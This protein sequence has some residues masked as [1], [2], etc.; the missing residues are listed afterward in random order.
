LI[1]SFFYI[2]LSHVPLKNAFLMPTYHVIPHTHWDREWYLSFDHFRVLLTHLMDDLLEIL[3]TNPDYK[4][5]TLDGQTSVL[6]DYL[7]IRPDRRPLIEKYVREGRLFIGPWYILP[8]EHLVSGEA[9]I[10]NLIRGRETAHAF[11]GSMDVGYIPDSFGHIAQMPQILQGFGIDSA[12]VWRGFGGEPGQEPSEYQWISPDGSQVLMEHLSDVGYSAAYFNSTDM[13]SAEERFEDFASRV[14]FRAQSDER[15]MLCGGDHHWPYRNL[16]LVLAHLNEQY[17]GDKVLVHS[18]ITAFMEAMK[19]GVAGKKLPQVH[20]EMRFGYRWAFNVTGGV[21]STR[22]YLKQANTAGQLLLERIL[23]PLDAITLWHGGRSQAHLIRQGWTYLM[24]NHPHDSICGCSIDPVHREMETRFEKLQEL[25]LGVERFAMMQILPD[26]EGDRGDDESLSLFNPSPFTRDE[27]VETDVEF[28]NQQIV[29]GLN[30]DVVVDPALPPVAGFRLQDSNGTNIPFEILDRKVDF[31]ISYN[32]FDYPAQSLVERFRLRFRSG[33]VPA[34]GMKA[35]RIVRTDTFAAEP[36]TLPSPSGHRISNGLV[37]LEAQQDGSYMLTDHETGQT[38]GPMGYFED[39]GDAGDEYNWSPPMKGDRIYDSRSSAKVHIE[40]VDGGLR[41]GL[42]ITGSWELP[43]GVT[44]DDNH[45][46]DQMKT[47]QFVTTAWL[48]EGEKMVR[49]ETTVDN[50]VKDHRFRVAFHTG[51]DTN[52]HWADVQFGVIEREQES[53]NPADFKIEVPAAVAPMQR[54]VCVEKGERAATLITN[55]MPE[56]ELRHNSKGTLLLTL[57]RCVSELGRGEIVMRPGGRG[58]WKNSTP[59]AQ[60]QGSHTFEY[61]FMP[62]T[63][64]WS[65]D[66]AEINRATESI[67]LPIRSSRRKLASNDLPSQLEISNPALVLSSF[68]PAED[69]KG[70]I[71]RFYNPSSLAQSGTLRWPQPAQ[72]SE[73]NLEEKELKILSNTPITSLE[74]SVEAYK[75]TTLRLEVEG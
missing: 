62:R 22:I 29:V 68:K 15:L 5:F 2:P 1:I 18:S 54:F 8:D 14:D 27:I 13:R 45:R 66:I 58:G 31:G 67:L 42:R 55:G 65:E 59:D 25:G 35:I 75:I 39:N 41:Q 74:M 30:P 44:E 63:K 40:I 21:Y 70:L 37:S 32:R 51:M 64:T 43:A 49:F 57:L 23:E 12:I 50:T 53:W 46:S 3:E 56:Y 38:Y 26:K 34:M 52:T 28:F 4:S 36:K 20:G 69:G 33:Q 16:P 10:R 6:D 7:E 73:C 48:T 61:A 24:Q 19:K 17:K 72:V 60:C 9:T 11:G 71:V 47:L